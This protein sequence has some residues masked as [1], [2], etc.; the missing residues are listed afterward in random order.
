[1]PESTADM[2]MERYGLASKAQLEVFNEMEQCR[3]FYRGDQW[4]ESRK[5]QGWSVASPDDK[6]RVRMTVNKLPPLVE[7]SIATFLRYRPIILCNPGSDENVDRQAAKVGQIL[8]RY[9]WDYLKF[10]EMLID[11]L[12]EVHVLNSSFLR[13]S[14]DPMK[15]KKIPIYKTIY[16]AGPGG[17]QIPI[18]TDEIESYKNEG[19]PAVDVISP[20]SMSIEPGAL[21]FE[22]CAWCITTELLRNDV[23]EQRF[24]TKVDTE[25]PAMDEYAHIPMMLERG[26]MENVK[27][28]AALHIYYERPTQKH[29][30]GRISYVCNRKTLHEEPLPNG[31]IMI[32]HLKGI[33]LVG[34]L[35]PTS[36][37]SQQLPMQMETNR[38]RSQLLENRNMC[39]RPQWIAADGAF[40]RGATGNRPGKTVKWDHI[41]AGGIEPHYVTPPQ[42]PGWVMAILEMNNQDMMDLAS[43]HEA[44]QGI[45][46]SAQTSGRQTAMFRSADDSRLSPA[47]RQF[48]SSLKETGRHI[49]TTCHINMRGEQ[50]IPIVGRGRYAEVAKFHA[51][52]ISDKINITYEIASQIP[53]ARE[54]MRQTI[55]DLNARGKMDDDTMNQLLELPTVQKLF[56][57]EQEHR[58]NARN[59]NEMLHDEYFPP[60]PTDAHKIHLQEHEADIN[61]PENRMALIKEMQMQQAQPPPP[62]EEMEG[63]PQPQQP[64][65]PLSIKNKLDHMEAHKKQI[66]QPQPP[67]PAPKVNLSLDRILNADIFK[68]PRNAGLLGQILP[69][70]MDVMKD[71]T[72]TPAT[73]SN[74]PPGQPGASPRAP[75]VKPPDQSLGAGQAPAIGLTPNE[76]TMM[77]GEGGG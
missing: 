65:F 43:R 75:G 23:I 55:T 6:W 9:Y 52:D 58:L 76:V 71:A 36:M 5:G 24:N 28:R 73:P 60:L 46:S 12:R 51:N 7:L 8:L 31:E 14:W 35:W 32:T 27:D 16:E 49:L 4:L 2:V 62:G 34:E 10:D 70:I 22:D 69:L 56:E 38:G 11:A 74:P 41:T 42:V 45:Q 57:H 26:V 19:S 21:R 18:Q 53:W 25:Q 77:G 30:N 40:E 20:F 17:L 37:C 13:T 67:A 59:E 54:S 61:L 64:Q 39:A 29:E 1:V 48:E 50:T 33:P 47:V 15:G 3:L 66:P 72:G 44:S 63:Q 68:D